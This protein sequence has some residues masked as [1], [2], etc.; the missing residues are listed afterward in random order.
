MPQGQY[1]SA[2]LSRST[3]SQGTQ[4]SP[5]TLFS[6]PQT[7]PKQ[8][9]STPSNVTWDAENSRPLLPESALSNFEALSL[10]PGNSHLGTSVNSDGSLASP[11]VLPEQRIFPGIVHE[12]VRR[13]SIL[14]PSST[15]EPGIQGSRKTVEGE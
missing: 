2:S 13:S 8:S 11:N 1:P 15:A 3:L 12:R 14:T 6:Q 7:P 4:T 9:L 5:S 10:Q